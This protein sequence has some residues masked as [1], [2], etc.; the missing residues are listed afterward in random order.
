MFRF[1][2]Q[3]FGKAPSVSMVQAPA[4]VQEPTPEQTRLAQLNIQ[5][6]EALQ[7][8]LNQAVG[9]ATNSLGQQQVTPDYTGLYAP[10]LQ[11]VQQGNQLVQQTAQGQLNPQFL[12]A[13]RAAVTSAM[14]PYTTGIN[15]LAQRGVFNSSQMDRYMN[16]AAQGIAGAQTQA[17][18]QNLA[19]QSQLANQLQQSALAPTNYA[20]ASQQASMQAPLSYLSAFTTGYQPQ[21]NMYGQLLNQQTALSAPAINQ[22]VVSQPSSPWGA[23]GSMQARGKVIA[24]VRLLC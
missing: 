18:G 21:Q 16:Q 24:K 19:Q 3:R 11:Q 17:Y 23:I 10:G 9:L 13:Q 1:N 12:E 7:P 22:A 20:A 6:V 15:Q 4:Q 5:Q 2:L 14:Q 8:V